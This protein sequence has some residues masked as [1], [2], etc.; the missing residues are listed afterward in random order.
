VPFT[1]DGFGLHSMRERMELLGG[2]LTLDSEPGRGT[3]VV[4]A[5]PSPS[6]YRPSPEAV[7]A[8]G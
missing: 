6:Q 3:R 4:A 1:R 7:H 5:V 2:T 8:A